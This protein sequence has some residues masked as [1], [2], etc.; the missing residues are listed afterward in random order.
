MQTNE[1]QNYLNLIL[2]NEPGK[3]NTMIY[4]PKWFGHLFRCCRFCPCSSL[5]VLLCGFSSQISPR[6]LLLFS[7]SLGGTPSSSLLLLPHIWA[8]S[9]SSSFLGHLSPGLLTHVAPIPRQITGGF[10]DIIKS[11]RH[12]GNPAH[13][14]QVQWIPPGQENGASLGQSWISSQ[15]PFSA[16]AERHP[17]HQLACLSLS[18]SLMW[19]LFQAH[20]NLLH[21][22]VSMLGI[23]KIVTAISH[24][25]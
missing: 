14:G 8:S 5:L 25:N 9:F 23:I 4:S 15:H 3:V 11:V 7:G 17:E 10:D 1:E 13:R 2:S 22:H 20:R 12:T 24:L 6:S 16:V 18:L 21:P 19:R